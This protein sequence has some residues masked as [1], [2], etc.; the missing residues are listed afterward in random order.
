VAII[1]YQGGVG[2]PPSSFFS[3]YIYTVYEGHGDHNTQCSA[4]RAIRILGCFTQ[5]FVKPSLSLRTYG[6]NKVVI[7][8]LMYEIS[9]YIYENPNEI[10]LNTDSLDSEE[11]VRQVS[12][13]GIFKNTK[14]QINYEQIIKMCKQ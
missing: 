8:N 3:T 4:L 6:L 10:S 14:K 1:T 11:E 5:S 2:C 13:Q 7:Y 9:H 12:I